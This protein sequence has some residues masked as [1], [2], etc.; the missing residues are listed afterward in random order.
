MSGEGWEAGWWIAEDFDCFSHLPEFLKYITKKK[1]RRFSVKIY[2]EYLFRPI[3]CLKWL[4]CF[5]FPTGLMLLI[6]SIDTTSAAGGTANT[7]SDYY[8]VWH[9]YSLSPESTLS[10][11]WLCR[12]KHIKEVCCNH[13]HTPA[14]R[15]TPL[16]T[17]LAVLFQALHFLNV[18]YGMLLLLLPFFFFKPKMRHPLY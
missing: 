12:E 5:S 13:L 4:S 2:N 7:A 9:F 11:W 8:S 16:R 15:I 18:T 10:I 1:E 6:C 17:P 3:H 14:H